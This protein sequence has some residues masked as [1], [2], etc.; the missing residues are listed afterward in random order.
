MKLRSKK[1]KKNT[2]ESF[3]LWEV[4][5]MRKKGKQTKK[6]KNAREHRADKLIEHFINKNKKERD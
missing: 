4:S 6:K 5:L 1:A 3:Y 2:E